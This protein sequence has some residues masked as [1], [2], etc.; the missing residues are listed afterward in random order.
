MHFYYDSPH[1]TYGG[2][3]T[4][5]SLD[6]SSKIIDKFWSYCQVCTKEING[7]GMYYYLPR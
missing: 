3:G 7:E 5:G 1:A 6:A 4:Y 2:Y